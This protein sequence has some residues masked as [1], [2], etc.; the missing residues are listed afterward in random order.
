MAAETV[1]RAPRRPQP[2]GV[3][4]HELD[5]SANRAEDGLRLHTP[6]F[7]GGSRRSRRGGPLD[8]RPWFRKGT[9]LGSA[10]QMAP[11]RHRPLVC[12]Q[13]S[14]PDV[15]S[16]GFGSP[17][18]S[19]ALAT[20]ADP[21]MLLFLCREALGL[22]E[23]AVARAQHL[24][25]RRHPVREQRLEQLVA[26]ELAVRTGAATPSSARPPHRRRLGT[27]GGAAAPSRRRRR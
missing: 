24:L 12:L 10:G 4:L 27:T 1:E 5:R 18:A 8:T 21:S 11:L 17:L 19:P 3:R 25:A 16:A 20:A 14:A 26:I 9:R 23:P 22:V 15:C 2:I 13:P 6:V 7:D